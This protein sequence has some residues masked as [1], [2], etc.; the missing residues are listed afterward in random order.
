MTAQ[1]LMQTASINA[2]SNKLALIRRG[3]GSGETIS[4]ALGRMEEALTRPDKTALSFTTT[5]SIRTPGKDNANTPTLRFLKRAIDRCSLARTTHCDGSYTPLLSAQSRRCQVASA[6]RLRRII[7]IAALILDITIISAKSAIAGEVEFELVRSDE[8]YSTLRAQPQSPDARLKYIALSENRSNWLSIGGE[9]RE[10]VETIDAIRFGLGFK[11]DNYVLQRLLLHGDLHVGSSFRIFAQVGQHSAYGKNEPLGAIDDNSTDIQNLFF[12]IALNTE[13]SNFV[14][15]GRQELQ[16]NST[17]RFVAVREGPNVRQSFEGG[18]VWWKT[19]EMRIDTFIARP[20]QFRPSTFDDRGD[21]SQ[22]FSGVYLAR[23][24]SGDSLEL[25]VLNLQR[26]D[27]RFGKR[28]GDERRHSIGGRWAVERAQFDMDAEAI[29]QFGKFAEG[30][31][32]AWAV[33]VDAGHTWMDTWSPR[34]GLRFDA[35]SGD[36]N[37]T[38]NRLQTFNPLYPKGGYFDQTGLTSWSNLLLARASLGLQPSNDLSLQASV[39]QRWRH[40]S[41][42]AVYVQPSVA[43]PLVSD[44]VSRNAGRSYQ[45]DASWK[46]NRNVTL[47]G[48]LAYHR[49]GLAITRSGGKNVSFAM[50]IAQYQF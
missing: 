14:R 11:S 39:M 4:A 46:V 1:R 40:T 32:S 13:Q 6:N 3:G 38:D 35:G 5:A 44:N 49:A 21:T 23:R 9:L 20:I 43:L 48:E 30:S 31:I 26:D 36:K 25:Y 22:S 18:R 2:I 16:F 7:S 15:L 17:Q 28:V 29:Y 41:T 34:I 24:T 19:G 12:D 50:L 8:D 42:D 33:S 47:S 27:V 45:I 37:P 10:R